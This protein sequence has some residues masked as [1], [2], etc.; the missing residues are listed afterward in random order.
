MSGAGVRKRRR[1]RLRLHTF[2]PGDARAGPRAVPAQTACRRGKGGLGAG[3]AFAA[4]WRSSSM[5][6]SSSSTSGAPSLRRGG[7]PG[8]R[9]IGHK[10]CRTRKVR[11]SQFAVSSLGVG[12]ADV[13]GELHP[14]GI[15]LA[16]LSTMVRLIKFAR[17]APISRAR[18]VFGSQPLE[19]LDHANHFHSPR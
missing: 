9:R 13:Y 2:Y 6:E 10:S 8:R 16:W 1:A 4:A 5:S 14:I 17:S 7:V 3:S 11:F 12:W 18:R 19:F 15:V